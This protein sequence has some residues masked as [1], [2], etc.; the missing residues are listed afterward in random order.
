[1]LYD[2]TVTTDSKTGICIAEQLSRSLKY[3][4]YIK[5]WNLSKCN[6]LFC[7][8]IWSYSFPSFG[9]KCF[10]DNSDVK[11]TSRSWSLKHLLNHLSRLSIIDESC[12]CLTV[13]PWLWFLCNI[14]SPIFLL[15]C[16]ETIFL[17]FSLVLTLFHVLLCYFITFPCTSKLLLLTLG[18]LSHW[19]WRN[20]SLFY[21]C[22]HGNLPCWLKA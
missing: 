20:W 16:H 6:I 11:E 21:W 10:T 18:C 8:N 14:F 7:V 1:M 22:S 13:V 17:Y 19:W 4:V 2:Q 3:H 9:G 15:H 12:S 5:V